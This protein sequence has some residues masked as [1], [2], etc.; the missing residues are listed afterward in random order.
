MKFFLG[1]DL[2]TDKNNLREDG[3]ELAVAQAPSDLVGRMEDKCD[4]F[5]ALINKARLP[6]PLLILL[7]LGMLAALLIVRMFTESNSA[8][9]AESKLPILILM[10]AY[11]VVLTVLLFISKA[12]R[13]KVLEGADLERVGQE[14]DGLAEAISAS[15]GIPEDAELFDVDIIKFPYTVKDGEPVPQPKASYNNEEMQVYRY[16]GKLYIA[17]GASLY[18]IYP[19]DFLGIRTVKKTLGLMMWN[20]DEE[21]NSETYA[22]YRVTEYKNRYS[23]P[24]YCILEF[25]QNGERYGIAFPNYELPTFTRLTGLQPTE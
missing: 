18:A 20:K 22:P 16:D 9:E 19:E 2:T 15:L 25:T 21:C 23:V 10:G 13:K 11:L 17:D 24:A 5:T 8:T 4:E 3:K 12:R 14:M 6:L 7:W 1:T